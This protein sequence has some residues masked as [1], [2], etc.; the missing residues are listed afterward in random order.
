MK[1][2]LTIRLI[3]SENL[4][5]AWDVVTISHLKEAHLWFELAEHITI[6]TLAL[7][8][9]PTRFSFKNGRLWI[10]LDV[11]TEH[12]RLR[13]VYVGRFRDKIPSEPLNMDNPDHH[14]AQ[15]KVIHAL[16]KA[17]RN[18]AVGLEMFRRDS[19]DALDKWITGKTSEAQFKPIYLDN[20]NFDWELYGPIFNYAQKNRIPMVGLNVARKITAQ[21]A[22]KGFASLNEAQRGALE[23]ITCDVTR[24]YREFISKAYGAHG[25]GKMTFNRF[26]E[27]QLV[28]D[29]AMAIYAIEYLQQQPDAVMVILAGSAHARKL[30]IPTQ[31]AKRTPGRLRLFCRKPMVYSILR[32]FQK[33]TLIL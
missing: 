5:R 7:N 17:G 24:Q 14:Q 3:P 6:E 22:H 20:W 13:L 8:G 21:V 32:L 4:L 18:V 26:C 31:L 15:L 9:R 19:Q 30:G 27:A 28:W 11:V 25:H 29:T 12:Q 23:G 33:M 10:P 2:D 1:H 16:H